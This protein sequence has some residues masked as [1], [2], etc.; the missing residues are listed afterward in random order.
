MRHK[1]GGFATLAVTVLVLL[2]IAALLMSSHHSLW[3]GLKTQQAAFS[4]RQTHRMAEAGLNLAESLLQ[5]NPVSATSD[6]RWPDL[7][8]W[9][10]TAQNIGG[11]ALSRWL[12]RASVSGAAGEFLEIRQSLLLYPLLLRLPPAPLTLG[13]EWHLGGKLDLTIPEAKPGTWAIWSPTAQP[14]STGM[15]RLCGKAP[16][17]ALP[18]G[19]YRADKH[20]DLRLE[21]PAFPQLLPDYLFGLPSREIAL[22]ELR[23][24]ATENRPD[25]RD[26][27]SSSQ[28]LVMISGHCQLSGEVGTANT[29]LL[30]V[31]EQGT[32][33][34]S[35]KS[36]LHG[37]LLLLAPSQGSATL[38]FASQSA[39]EGAVVV[40]G[41]LV[42]NGSRGQILYDQATLRALQQLPQVQRLIRVPGSW[43]DW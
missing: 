34:L 43:R 33:L 35:E 18:A 14:L 25:C 20:A 29:P 30:L 1:H 28:G 15:L 16:C 4:Y 2:L 9:E 10:R 42:I 5:A 27:S 17:R 23:G 40:D 26:L 7:V 22:S 39:I 36:R 41:E 3:Q 13:G 32:L 21:D 19:L 37:L 38:G 8:S 24:M 12:L 31:V 6:A 11:V